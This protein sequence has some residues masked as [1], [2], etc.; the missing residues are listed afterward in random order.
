MEERDPDDFEESRMSQ[1]CD[2]NA[3]SLDSSMSGNPYVME[4]LRVGNRE[5]GDPVGRRLN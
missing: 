3:A 1:L 4:L 5:I 2:K